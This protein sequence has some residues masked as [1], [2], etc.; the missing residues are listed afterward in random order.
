V[1]V[2]LCAAKT[3]SPISDVCRY[4]GAPAHAA[5]HATDQELLDQLATPEAREFTPDDHGG[6]LL[7]LWHG[8]RSEVIANADTQAELD[9]GL[10]PGHLHRL[11]TA[12][13]QSHVGL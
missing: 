2:L 1:S 11:I 6:F 9:A 5:T 12:I 8:L 13:V 4:P 3:G 7:Q 10:N